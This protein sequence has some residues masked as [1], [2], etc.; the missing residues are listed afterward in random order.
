MMLQHPNRIKF[1]PSDQEHR[2]AVRDFLK[3]HSWGD[4]KMRFA[5]DPAFNSIATQV[6]EKLLNWYLTQ[7]QNEQPAE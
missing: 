5:E 3:R 2:L 1:D 6:Q 7:E 4:V